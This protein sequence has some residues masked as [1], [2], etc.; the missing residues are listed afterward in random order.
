MR[1]L[2]ESSPSCAAG[3][4]SL[5]P[6][7]D[8]LLF[9][10]AAA[11]DV[12]SSDEDA[13][14]FSESSAVPA[15]ATLL[16]VLVSDGDFLCAVAATAASGRGRF[17]CA[18]PVEVEDDD[19]GGA[20]ACCCCCCCHAAN[21]ALRSAGLLVEKK[22]ATYSLIATAWDAAESVVA[23]W[24]RRDPKVPADEALALRIYDK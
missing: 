22:R 18:A 17:F 14:L 13:V 19:G 9:A 2:E 20:A 1:S 23:R 10:D 21:M 5:A 7:A 6:G 3:Y 4:R 8:D 15:A 24:R 12:P 16:A 11:F